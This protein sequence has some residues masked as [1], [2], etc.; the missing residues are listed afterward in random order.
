MAIGLN[1]LAELLHATNR[2]GE[3]ELLYLRALVIFETSLGRNHPQTVTARD[4]LTML[5]DVRDSGAATHAPTWPRHWRPPLPNSNCLDEAELMRRPLAFDETPDAAIRLNNLA[6]LLQ[7]ANRFDEAEPLLRRALTIFERSL[8]PAHPD[9]MTAR[10][11]LA[12]LDAAL[13]KGGA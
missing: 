2:L 10:N 3:A 12:A 1:N 9:T 6:R 8:G 13:G 5:E 11:N 7:D 4:N